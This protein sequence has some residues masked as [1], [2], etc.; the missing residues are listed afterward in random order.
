MFEFIAY[1][2]YVVVFA[3]ASIALFANERYPAT[4]EH[5]IGCL[6]F[7][8]LA[9][10]VIKNIFIVGSTYLFLGIIFSRWV[11]CRK[12]LTKILTSVF[13]VFLLPGYKKRLF[14]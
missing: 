10:L 5:F 7:G 9:M 2:L 12:P 4:N 8:L 1:L 6:L 11:R 13:W 3:N 14:M